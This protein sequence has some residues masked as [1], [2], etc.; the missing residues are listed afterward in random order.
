MIGEKIKED[1]LDTDDRIFKLKG[2]GSSHI[3]INYAV[4]RVGRKY[5]S[6]AAVEGFQKHMQREQ[7]TPNAFT[8]KTINN[9]ILI[10][11]SYIYEDVKKYLIDCKIRTN[12]VI[13]RDMLLTSSKGFFDKLL[14]D[15]KEK[16]IELNIKWLKEKFGD[17]CV[18]AVLHEDE[19]TCH[20][21]ALIVPKLWSE[22]EKCYTLQNYRYFDGK[23]ALSKLQDEYSRTMQTKFNLSRGLK[24]SKAKHVEIA[25]FYSMINRE[26]DEKNVHSVCSKALNADLLEKK[27]M[28]LQNTLYT[29]KSFIEKSNI[30][31]IELLNKLSETKQEK[32][33]YEESIKTLAK[34]HNVKPYEIKK[35]LNYAQQ[36]LKN[37][38]VEKELEK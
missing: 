26:L 16:W 29:Y 6:I 5:K 37:V 19:T 32:D 33:L 4:F 13:A 9:R 14:P 22:Y 25:K 10:G 38:E 20:V 8:E 11:S 36:N 1:Y 15:E 12:S 34:I 3:T 24:F 27:V 2:I 35:V 21:H 17:N 23:A 31:K 28:D 7:E 30:E 18:Y